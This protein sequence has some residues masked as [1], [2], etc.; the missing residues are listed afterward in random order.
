MVFQRV[1]ADQ[2]GNA[3]NWFDAAV[4]VHDGLTA[5]LTALLLQLVR[6][7]ALV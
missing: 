1:V 4:T 2:L 3:A 7:V 6:T 5:M